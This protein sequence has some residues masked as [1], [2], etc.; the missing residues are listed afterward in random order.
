ME[1]LQCWF[2]RFM[3]SILYVVDLRLSVF[4]VLLS[5]PLNDVDPLSSPECP[6]FNNLF[7]AD[8]FPWIWMI[9]WCATSAVP[10]S[11][12]VKQLRMPLICCFVH[13]ALNLSL[14]QPCWMFFVTVHRRYFSE[15]VCSI[16]FAWF[17][18]KSVWLLSKVLTS[19]QSKI[20][21]E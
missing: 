17:L 20:E 12:K 7:P 13:V 21:N 18:T 2:R 15:I 16:C 6:S 4:F 8:A 3:C 19:I 14:I 10:S 5:L 11:T 9:V 1:R